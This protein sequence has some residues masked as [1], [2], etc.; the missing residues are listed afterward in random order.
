[1]STFATSAAWERI[2]AHGRAGRDEENVVGKFFHFAAISLF[3]LTQAEIDDRIQF[4][5]LKRFGEIVLRAQLH[6]V[7]DFARVGDTRQHHDLHAG[8]KLAQLLQS[9]QAVYA[10][11]ENVEQHQIGLQ[12]LFYALQCFLARGG[13][14][15]FVVVH[16]QQ[17]LDVTQH[18]GFI[19]HQ[20]DFGGLLHRL[21]FPL[22][23]AV[24]AGL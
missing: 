12:T 18:A 22:L 13:C 5:F 2:F 16:F 24:V 23:A 1:M 19:V 8:L 7:Y 6:R 10:G 17:S 3:P 11:H 14:F 4:G 21:F 20:Q 9:L 15:N